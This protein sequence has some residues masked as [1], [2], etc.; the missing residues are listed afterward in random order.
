MQ[1]IDFRAGRYDDFERRQIRRNAT[2][3]SLERVR[4][5]VYAEV[6]DSTAE[7]RHRR[8]I[9]AT[10]PRLASD[11]TVSHTSAAIVHGLPVLRARL[12]PV[13]TTRPSSNGKRSTY[14]H[15]RR[16]LLRPEERVERAGLPLTSL[17]RTVA[18]LARMLPFDEALAAAD[19]AVRMGLDIRALAEHEGA[20]LRV[21]RVAHFASGLSE[22]VGESM[23]RALFIQSGLPPATLQFRVF[24]RAGE[25]FARCDFGWSDW[26]VVGEFDGDVKYGGTLPGAGD[27]ARAIRDEKERIEGLRDLG[28]DPIQWGW[29]VMRT[30]VCSLRGYSEH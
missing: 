26:N 14:V 11:A 9:E 19:V 8:L 4:P 21:R 23:S 6:A 3:G 30:P 17:G 10:V 13:M 2:R 5:G 15:A 25:L 27:P 28:Y 18:D 12:G 16:A 7:E 1:L 20:S 24:N 29:R 22:S